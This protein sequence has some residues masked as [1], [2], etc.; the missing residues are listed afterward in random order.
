MWLFFTDRNPFRRSRRNL[1]CWRTQL[2]SRRR[3]P[4]FIKTVENRSGKSDTDARAKVFSK[5]VRCKWGLVPF[6]R[7]CCDWVARRCPPTRYPRAV[8]WPVI[9]ELLHQ[10]QEIIRATAELSR[11]CKGAKS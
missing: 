7:R 1:E 11:N 9:G 3:F 4:D 6:P 10:T 8:L 5:L 2:K